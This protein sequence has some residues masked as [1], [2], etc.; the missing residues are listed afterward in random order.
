[1]YQNGRGPREGDDSNSA[2]L[3][4][5]EAGHREVGL[6]FR[7]IWF[8]SLITYVSVLFAALQVREGLTPSG[9]RM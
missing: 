1:M 8:T 9:D 2:L 4:N 7:S 3:E 5:V 6:C